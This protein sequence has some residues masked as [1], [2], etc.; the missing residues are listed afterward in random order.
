MKKVEKFL[1]KQLG[2]IE[3]HGIFAGVAQL[4]RALPCQG[5]GRGFESLHPLHIAMV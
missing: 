2:L 3:W 4:I 1:Q 5:R